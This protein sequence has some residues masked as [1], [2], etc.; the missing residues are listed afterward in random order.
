VNVIIPSFGSDSIS[1]ACVEIT[2]FTLIIMGV[3]NHLTIEKEADLDSCGGIDK[4]LTGKYCW[5]LLANGTI[6]L[7]QRD[8]DSLPYANHW[9][10]ELPSIWTRIP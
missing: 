3:P 6:K 4:F 10:L 8:L 9:A 1:I 2:L 7:V 5:I